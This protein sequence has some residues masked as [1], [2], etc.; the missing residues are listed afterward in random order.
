MVSSSRG[1]RY[2]VT[3]ERVLLHSKC[4]LLFQM[5]QCNLLTFYE[6]N[7]KESQDSLQE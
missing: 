3:S 2:R 5:I 1:H 4:N 7:L 6:E